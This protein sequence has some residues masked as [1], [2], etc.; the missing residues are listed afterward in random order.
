MEE[1]K[2]TGVWTLVA[3]LGGKFLSLLVKSSK[4]LKVGLAAAT[5]ASYTWFFTWK[6]AILLMIAIGFHEA[7]HVFAMKRLGIRT[8][9]WFFLPFLGGVAIAEEGYISYWENAYVAIAGPIGGAILAWTTMLVYWATGDP[10]WAAAAAFQAVLNILN[11]LPISPLDGGQMV[12]SITF[13][14]N[15][16]LGAV[17]LLLSFIAAMFIMFKLRIGLFG[18]LLIVG[19]IEVFIEW[20]YRIRMLNP[21]IPKWMIPPH[22]LN[23][24]YPRSMNKKELALASF[25]YVSTIAVL[26]AIILLTKKIAGADLAA[27]FLE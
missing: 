23:H 5:F 14:I 24:K 1:K 7:S 17:F 4:L 9:G 21:N 15:K 26:V 11:L 3:K 19:G 25:L 13:S 18:L 27:Q 8:R 2:R 20:S 6:F 10:M 22:V 12:R 16:W